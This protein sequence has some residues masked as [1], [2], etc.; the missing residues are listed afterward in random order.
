[1]AIFTISTA[2]QVNLPPKELGNITK[3]VANGSTYTFTLADF[4]TSTIPQYQDPEGDALARIKIG[5]IVAINGVIQLSAV[6]LATNAEVTSADIVAGNLTWVDDGINT[7][8]H[9]S[10]FNFTASD[11]GSLTFSTAGGI[12]TMDVAATANAAP[13]AVGDRTEGINYGDTLVFTRAMFT[14]LTTPAYADPEGDAA[15][16][17]K[18]TGLPSV[19]VISLS[20]VPVILNQEINFTDIDASNLT[21]SGSL[22]TITSIS[23]N[24]NFEIA[25]T[26]SGIFVG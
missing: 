5:S 24:F 1:M 20:G 26:V 6:T 16:L 22:S 12:V 14:T 25:D 23:S 10:T 18:I 11:T 19:G 17:L 9:S 4:T 21:F 15:G 13:T 8:A 2:A 7:F 3:S